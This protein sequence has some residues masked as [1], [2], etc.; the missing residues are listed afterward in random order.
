M[1]EFEYIT[2]KI[3]NQFYDKALERANMR[4]LSSATLYLKKSLKFNKNNFKSRNLLALI[5]YEVG[6]TTDA[7]VQWIISRDIH[8]E[9]TYNP[10][11]DTIIVIQN[12]KDTP[13]AFESIKQYNEAIDNIEMD[14]YDLAL[15]KLYKSVELNQN[16]IK[17]MTLLSILLLLRGDHIKA[18][19][20]LRKCQKIDIG[21]RLVNDLMDY[22]LRNTKKREVR[23]KKLSN[24]YSIRK[25]ESDDAI[26]PKIYVKLSDN[27]KV[28]FVVVG[29]II[30]ILAYTMIISPNVR[31]NVRN[32]AN[33]ELVKYVD[34]VNDQ[35]KVIRD[36]SIENEQLKTDY[37]SASVRLRAY[38]EQ[39]RLFTSQYETLN[40]II[41]DFDGGYISRA[42]RAY[43]ELDKESITDETLIDLLNQARSRIEGIGAKRLTELGTESWNGGN[44]QAALAYYQLSLSIN[45]NDP[46]TMWLLARLYQNGLSQS[47][48]ANELFDRIISQHPDSR[49]ASRAREARGY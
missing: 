8:K 38:E 5:F 9:Q 25:L 40:G 49:Y 19:A 24:I 44:K 17:S 11:K 4:D 23:E 7:L 31:Y 37:D 21:N 36:L 26:L 14:R 22:T 29:M 43:V 35:N 20:F 2:K 1:E 28:I 10:A 13:M 34:L 41:T 39:N 47:Q 48:R 45:P 3:S 42:A 18:G 33:E 27:Q 12:E 15:M 16:N 30:G 32:N 6:A 46:E